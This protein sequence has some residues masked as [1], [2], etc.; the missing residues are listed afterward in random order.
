MEQMAIGQIVAAQAVQT[1]KRAALA[2]ANPS[3]ADRQVASRAT[4]E[5]S[6][7][8]GEV[9]MERQA[10]LLETS[11]VRGVDTPPAAAGEASSA[12]SS[13]SAVLQAGLAVYANTAGE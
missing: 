8:Q 7:A 3:P 5:I 9:A 10:E 12:S 6:R 13:G 1:I 2:P 4:Q 11:F